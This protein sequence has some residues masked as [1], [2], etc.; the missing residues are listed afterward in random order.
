MRLNGTNRGE[1]RH[2]HIKNRLIGKLY[3]C[4]KKSIVYF[5]DVAYGWRNWN[6]H[7]PFSHLNAS[8]KTCRYLTFDPRT[9]LLPSS[10]TNPAE[11]GKFSPQIYTITSEIIWNLSPP[12]KSVLFR[13]IFYAGHF[14]RLVAI[15][16]K[17][18]IIIG[19][20]STLSLY[21]SCL[22]TAHYLWLSVL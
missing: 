12:I 21:N 16:S 13:I 3:D 22:Y 14:S 17:R 20:L 19:K 2:S 9:T 11:I 15:A 8:A 1:R 5:N 7:H 4:L 10:F 18:K 6:I